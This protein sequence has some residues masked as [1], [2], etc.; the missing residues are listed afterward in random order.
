LCTD[1]FSA[2]DVE[3]LSTGL[4]RLLDMESR[5]VSRKNPKGNKIFRIYIPWRDLEKMW[6]FIGDPPI[7]PLA[8]RWR[9]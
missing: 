1:G 2:E 7:A 6:Q 8:H 3:F 9:L 4:N 5:S